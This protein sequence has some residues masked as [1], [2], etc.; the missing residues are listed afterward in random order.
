[1]YIILFRA[2]IKPPDKVDNVQKVEGGFNFKKNIE[3][4]NTLALIEKTDKKTDFK[5][6]EL[7]DPISKKIF[8]NWKLKPNQLEKILK[9]NDL[10]NLKTLKGINS[11]K[12]NLIDGSIVFRFSNEESNI[13]IKMDK[14]SI[15]NGSLTEM[16]AMNFPHFITIGD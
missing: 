7:I 6:V 12:L 1:M 13:L 15:L 9:I 11:P 14:D 4:N 10:S 16:K 5:Y 3:L 8:H 2:I